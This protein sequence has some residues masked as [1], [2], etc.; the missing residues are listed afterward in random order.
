MASQK[1]K[2]LPLKTTTLPKRPR[3]SAYTGVTGMASPQEVVASLPKTMT[4]AKRPRK[5]TTTDRPRKNKLLRTG[6]KSSKTEETP[7]PIE[8]APKAPE[9]LF[10]FDPVITHWLTFVNPMDAP[11]DPSSSKVN[12][13]AITAYDECK[14]CICAG[15]TKDPPFPSLHGLEFDEV[16]TEEL[17]LLHREQWAKVHFGGVYGGV[18]YAVL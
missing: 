2:A 10:V 11:N 12:E 3:H 5:N 17:L 8:E 7:Q 6:A 9:K 14:P 13:L 1:A 4:L 18:Y 15:I 16:D